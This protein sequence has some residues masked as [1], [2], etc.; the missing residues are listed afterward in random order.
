MH[1]RSSNIPAMV[2]VVTALFAIQAI[3]GVVLLVA[4]WRHG[5]RSAAS[6]AGHVVAI[7]SAGVVWV[8]FA[9]TGAIGWAWL[10]VVLLTIGNTL[11]DA[12]LR[13]RWRGMS[14]RSEGF[15]RD[16]GGAI[17]AV[18]RGRMPKAVVF[19]A[20]FAGAVYFSCLGVAIGATVAAVR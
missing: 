16:Y 4:W 12:L 9:V 5:R 10:A 18:F 14:G 6:I 3:A 19:H 7:G 15:G 8:V 1:Y 17:G 13:R 20:L 11:G 2:H